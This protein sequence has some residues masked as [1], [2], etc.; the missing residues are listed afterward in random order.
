MAGKGH[1]DDDDN[2]SWF[3]FNSP[4]PRLVAKPRPRNPILTTIYPWLEEEKIVSCFSP[5][6]QYEMKRKQPCLGF[7]LGSLILFP[8]TITITLRSAGSR[9]CRLH[10]LQK[11]RI[12]PLKKYGG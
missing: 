4:S 6:H 7:E 11:S 5:E 12:I 3:E 1:G 8:S 9:I 10:T 2:E